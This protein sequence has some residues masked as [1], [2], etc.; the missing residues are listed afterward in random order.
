[1]I[2]SPGR[3]TPFRGGGR[4]RAINGITLHVRSEKRLSIHAR[5]TG[6]SSERGNMAE[7]KKHR[8]GYRN[9]AQEP[10]GTPHHGW[11][12]RCEHFDDGGATSGCYKFGIR[13]SWFGTCKEWQKK[14]GGK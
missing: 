1:M 6:E 9:T 11:C 8:I 5:P 2:Y 4:A 14:G 3:Y 7:S 13:V 12:S 10:L